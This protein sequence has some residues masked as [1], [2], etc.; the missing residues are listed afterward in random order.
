D[1]AERLRDPPCGR[2]LAVGAGDG[3]DVE[4]RARRAEK[5]ARDLAGGGFQPAQRADARLAFER[6]AF[7]ALGLDEAGMGAGGERGLDE[8]AA[9]RRAARPGDEAIARRDL[10]AVADEPADAALREPRVRGVARREPRHP[11]VALASH[12]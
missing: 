7:D 4:L 6:E 3:D 2:G 11:G 1:G 8:A 10:P 12:L 5:A 9:V